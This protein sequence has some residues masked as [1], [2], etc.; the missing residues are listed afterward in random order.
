MDVVRDLTNPLVPIARRREL[1]QEFSRQFGWRPHDFVDMPGSLP[2][3]NLVVE[4]GLDDSAMLSFLPSSHQVD[5]ISDSERRQILSLSYNSLIDWHIWIDRDTVRCFQNRSQLLEPLYTRRFD[6]S[7]HSALER[8]VFDEAVGRAPNPNL[9]AL[10]NALLGSLSDW[11]DILRYQIPSASEAIAALFNAIILA[12]AVEDFD[13]RVKQPGSCPSL[14]EMVRDAGTSIGDAIQRLM[15]EHDAPAPIVPRQLFDP[16]SLKRFDGLSPETKSDLVEAF[17]RHRSVPYD[18]D[19]SVMSKH[20]L[21]K[22]YE[23]YVAVM[24]DDR[25]V[26]LSMFPSSSEEEWNRQ[27]GGV[28]TPQYIATF[29]ARYLRRLFPG[30]QFFKCSVADPACGSGIFLRSVMEQ[31]LM[32][33]SGSVASA[34]DSVFGIDVDGNA[35]SAASLSL[36]LLH[37]AALGH[38]PEE[39]PVVQGNSFCPS[40]FPPGSRGPFDAVIV[41]PPFVRTEMQTDE[42]REAISKRVGGLVRFKPDAYLAFLVASIESLRPGGFGCFVVPQS[43]LTSDNLKRLRDWIIDQAWVHLVAD[44]SAVRVFR[45]SVYVVLLVVQKKDGSEM[46]APSVSVIRCQKDV[47]L[48]LDNFLD[49]NH[50]RTF[51]YSIF[52]ARQESLSRPT[53][54]V[55]LPEEAGLLDR[56]ESFPKLGGVADVRQGVITG[57]DGVFVLDSDRVPL[58]EEAVYRPL[59]PDRMIG[60]Y[61]LPGETGISV[62]YPFL[63]EVPVDDSQMEIDF[64]E[65]WS[66]LCLHREKLSSRASARRSPASWWRPSW[67]RSPDRILVPKIVVPKVFL[68]PRFGVDLS[69]RWIVSHSPLVTVRSGADDELLLLL[70]AVLNSSVVAWYLGMNGRKFQHGYSEVGVSL[71]RRLPI[72]D[73]Q[74]APDH[75]VRQV[76]SSARKLSGSFE[77]F[78]HGV[79]SSLDDLVLRNLYSLN[80]EEINI[81]KPDAV[82]KPDA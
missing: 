32:S 17:Y 16:D 1:G 39:V 52:S 9:L 74:F 5:S 58:G 8:R 6:Q 68:I 78:D 37:L 63:D 64:P 57:A 10:D 59:L 62:F 49:G 46:G 54:S 40:V 75:V 18:Y 79:A 53:W 43:L 14:L 56:L 69:G 31:K 11:R 7:D 38:L 4:R 15:S 33:G 20:A 2:V 47:G 72:P 45:S 51:S 48:A 76:V 3:A 70:A 27:L 77:E 71:L 66:R 12:R 55:P 41:N 36:A 67:P 25:S 61:A 23:R 28:Y 30:E 13:A 24:R 19:F 80:D 29:F 26:Q 21:S 60:R 44:L 35:V 65:T 34:F 81:L 73:L 22:L 50:R 82:L 42:V